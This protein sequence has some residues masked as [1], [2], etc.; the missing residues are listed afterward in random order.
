MNSKVKYSLR[1]VFPYAMRKLHLFLI[2]FFST[3]VMHFR[4]RYW[5][6]LFGDS[7][8][9]WGLLELEVHPLASISIGSNCIFRSHFLSNNIGLLRRCFISAGR[10]AEIV[11]GD[12]VGMSGTIISAKKRI[13]IGSRVM[14]GGNVVITDSDRHPLN[15]HARAS[16]QLPVNADIVIGDDVWLGMNV[17]IL[18]GVTIGEGTVVAAN[19]VVSKNLPANVVAAGNPARVIKTLDD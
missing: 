9:F 2:G 4:L 19:S 1:K 14:F 15:K 17:V 10:D 11:I 13:I 18:K 16:G 7:N 5:N 3:L 12:F 6:I 8:K